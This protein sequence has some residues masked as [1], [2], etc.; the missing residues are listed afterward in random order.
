M[1]LPGWARASP[2]AAEEFSCDD[3]GC[4]SAELACDFAKACADG[5]DENNCGESQQWMW[6]TQLTLPAALAVPGGPGS[7]VA[8][9]C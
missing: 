8:W 1:E 4:V 6:G 7:T 5:S 9:L 2:C 3:G